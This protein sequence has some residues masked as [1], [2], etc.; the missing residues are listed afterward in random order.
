[1]RLSLRNRLSAIGLLFIALV[2]SGCDDYLNNRD[3]ISPIT[4]D[5]TDANT[6]IQT[7]DPW[8]PS[9]YNTDIPIGN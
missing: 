1:M 3:R 8:P 7:V 9:S 2:L 4:G 6:A 5:A